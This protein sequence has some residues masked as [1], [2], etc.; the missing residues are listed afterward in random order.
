MLAFVVGS[1]AGVKRAFLDS[2]LEGGRFPELER[3]RWLDIIVAVNQIMWL[4]RAGA[5]WGACYH[6]R[7]AR[8]GVKLGVQTQVTTVIGQPLGARGEVLPMLGLGR[9]ARKPYVLTEFSNESVPIFTKISL[10]RFH[11]VLL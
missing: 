3:F 1:A 10:D 8:R 4:A 5:T 7:V 11:D 9:N 6:D 2:R